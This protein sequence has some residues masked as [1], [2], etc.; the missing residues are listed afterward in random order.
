MEGGARGSFRPNFE[1]RSRCIIVRSFR[2]IAQAMYLAVKEVHRVVSGRRLRVHC[3]GHSL[4]AHA[5]GFLGKHLIA[6]PAGTDGRFQL[7]LF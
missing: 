4:G 6:D 1:M 7:Q 3:V 5:C 2:Y